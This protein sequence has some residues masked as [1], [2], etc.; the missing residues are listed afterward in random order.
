MYVLFTAACDESRQKN[1]DKNS[2][3]V[4]KKVFLPADCFFILSPHPSAWFDK[5]TILLG[6]T[7]TPVC[8]IALI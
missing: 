2:Y 8:E 5:L 3:H 4:E 6:T 7:E 1:C